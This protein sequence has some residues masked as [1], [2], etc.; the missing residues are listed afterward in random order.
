[1]RFE[2]TDNLQ[3]Q[4]VPRKPFPNAYVLDDLYD[5]KMVDKGNDYL[6]DESSETVHMEG[7][8]TF[9]YIFE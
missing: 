7:C 8:E 4:R 9:M 5:E 1:V 6:L 2:K 3:K